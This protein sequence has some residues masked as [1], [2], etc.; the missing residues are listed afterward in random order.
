[1]AR[2]ALALA[3]LTI[4]SGAVVTSTTYGSTVH[5]VIGV[6]FALVTLLVALRT[7][8]SL[9]WALLALV[10][11]DAGLAFPRLNLVHAIFAQ[12]T[13]GVAVLA[14]HRYGE[15]PPE[16]ASLR[17]FAIAIP[18]LVL[19]QTALGAAYRHKALGV[20]PHMGGAMVVVLV[21]LLVCVILLQRL[22]KPGPLRST[23][24]VLMTLVLVQIS[25]G[26]AAFLMRL[27]DADQ[28]PVFPWIAVA[29]VTNG[30][31]TLGASVILAMQFGAESPSDRELDPAF[32]N[33]QSDVPST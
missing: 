24:I 18:P 20:L 15:C 11:V 21:T 30:A 9:T 8:T 5:T 25:L 1:M 27:L 31:L 3:L 4:C 17:R 7:R 29:H 26:I 33:T 12:L 22:Q 32:R 13:F 23:A 2:A 10:A 6:V 14:T 16:A 19:F 28:G